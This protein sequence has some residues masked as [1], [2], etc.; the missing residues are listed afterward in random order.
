MERI[1][2]DLENCT[3]GYTILPYIYDSD[4]EDNIFP[5]N[6]SEKEIKDFEQ[7]TVKQANIYRY[8]IS[9]LGDT[10]VVLRNAVIVKLFAKA[11][12]VR[13]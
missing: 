13:G 8:A 11:H 4:N 2:E 10:R 5:Q 9:G 6:V 7:E 3:K 12:G 1:F